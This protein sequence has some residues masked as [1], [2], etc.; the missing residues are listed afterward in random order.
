[1]RHR[2][3]SIAAIMVAATVAAA[4]PAVAGGAKAVLELFTS[5]G[6]SSCPPADA[7]L[8]D[9]AGRDDILALSFP[10]DYW[11]YLGWK[12]TLA[13]HD[14]TLRQKGYAEAR[15]DRQVYTPQ[16]VVNGATHVVGSNRQQIESA[17]RTSPP[18]PVPI[19]MKAGTD[20]T[21]VTIGA[22]DLPGHQ[23]GTIWLA[24]YDDPVT[25]PIERGENT[26]KSVTYYNV[27]R[28]LRP[29]AMW[30]G[31]EVTVDLPKSELDQ[32]EVSRCAVILQTEGENGLPGPILGAANIDYAH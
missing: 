7:M 31:K 3:G 6:C 14:N 5:Q 22:A 20:S 16:I 32:A 4:V 29:I 15:G 24:M 1:M 8:G 25:V 21:T 30:K 23:K 12:D 10:V 27:V 13:S 18:L 2:A 17:L 28:K 11:D 26:G 9:Y 19:T